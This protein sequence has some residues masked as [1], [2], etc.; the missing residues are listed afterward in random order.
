MDIDSELLDLESSD[1]EERNIPKSLQFNNVKDPSTAAIARN[2][3]QA[4]NQSIGN[5]L[6]KIEQQARCKADSMQMQCLLAK[7]LDITRI[8]LQN[9]KGL[10]DISE[11]KYQFEC[12]KE[13]LDVIV[14]ILQQMPLDLLCDY[15]QEV[16]YW[17]DFT[18]ENTEEITELSKAFTTKMMIKLN[19]LCEVKNYVQPNEQCT[20]LSKHLSIQAKKLKEEEKEFAIKAIQYAQ[21][22]TIKEM[23]SHA[24][25]IIDTAKEQTKHL[26]KS[27][28]DA[29]ITKLRKGD[30][31]FNN[32]K[33]IVCLCLD[34]VIK[35]NN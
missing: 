28:V 9:S 1:E 14:D 16:E 21:L 11:M 13:G 19:A 25:W 15:P 8:A 7:L 23:Y 33:L 5:E 29:I 31:F 2:A 12:K 24:S 17:L 10:I 32:T 4:V 26:L 20:D 34:I 22:Q 35:K 6:R 3:R 18:L 30:I 27:G